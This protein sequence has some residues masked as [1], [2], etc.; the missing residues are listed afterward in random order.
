M[1]K[2]RRRPSQSLRLPEE[3]RIVWQKSEWKVGVTCAL[4]L[5]A[6]MG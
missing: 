1:T 4:G 6:R 5:F 2:K 3:R